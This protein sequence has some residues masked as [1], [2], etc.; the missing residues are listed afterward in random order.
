M[1]IKNEK[2]Q[3]LRLHY[4]ILLVDHCTRICEQMMIQAIDLAKKITEND[5]NFMILK[6]LNE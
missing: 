6:I 5:Q 4:K 2:I 1:K 3:T